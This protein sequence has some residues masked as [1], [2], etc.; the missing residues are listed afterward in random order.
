LHYICHCN[1]CRCGT[2]S[3]EPPSARPK[4]HAT[5]KRRCATASEVAEPPLGAH[6]VTPRRGY[7]HHGIYAGE[8][9]VIHYAGLSR[10]IERGPVEEVSLA[11]FANARPVMIRC[12]GSMP[13]E[14]PEIVRRARSRLGE[15]RYRLL[16]NNCEHFSEWAQFGLHRS[17]QVNRFARLPVSAAASLA[18]GFRVV[19]RSLSDRLLFNH[20]GAAN[21]G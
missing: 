8:G 20:A 16:S 1:P 4:R 14:V 9:M 15:N 11:R 18:Q 12:R 10:G 7:T 13:F 21:Q 3:H 17:A 5:G 6:L 19:L 2:A